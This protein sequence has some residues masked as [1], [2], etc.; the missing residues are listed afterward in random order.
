MLYFRK[1]KINRWI[2]ETLGDSY[3]HRLIESGPPH[4]H[5]FEQIVEDKI[6]RTLFWLRWSTRLKSL[7]PFRIVVKYY[8]KPKKTLAQEFA[9]REVDPGT[10]SW[11]EFIRKRFGFSKKPSEEDGGESQLDSPK[12]QV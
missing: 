5:V 1:R 8:P 11:A 3:V 9:E 6:A 4:E 10:S 12:D 2:A 7:Y